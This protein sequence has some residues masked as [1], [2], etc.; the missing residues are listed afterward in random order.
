MTG[1]R[2]REGR[3][4]G[5]DEAPHDASTEASPLFPVPPFDPAVI[6]ERFAAEAEVRARPGARPEPDETPQDP[7][8]VVGAAVV[9]FGDEAHVVAA[10]RELIPAVARVVVVDLSSEDNTEGAVRRA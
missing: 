5:E 4:H 3:P 2:G 6:E 8:Q 10:L 9:T 1:D 7:R